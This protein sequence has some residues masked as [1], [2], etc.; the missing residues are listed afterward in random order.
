MMPEISLVEKGT[1]SPT[2]LLGSVAL[3]SVKNSPVCE[4]TSPFKFSNNAQPLQ[5]ST[6]PCARG[7]L[8]KHPEVSLGCWAGFL[9]APGSL[10][11]PLCRVRQHFCP[12]GTVGTGLNRSAVADRH[13][14]PF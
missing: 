4:I 7:G 6:G 2:A 3:L 8:S 5:A 1:S 10:H 14:A 11:S 13:Q 9:A 12:A